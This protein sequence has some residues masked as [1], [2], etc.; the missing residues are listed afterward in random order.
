MRDYTGFFDGINNKI[1]VI[2]RASFGFRD[3]EYFFLKIR[4]AFRRPIHIET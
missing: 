4:G 3:Q 1:R 2:K